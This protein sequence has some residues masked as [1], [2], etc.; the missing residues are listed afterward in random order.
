[1]VSTQ[2]TGVVFIR[3]FD[4]GVIETLGAEIR[5]AE[6]DG[7][8]RRSYYMD[9]IGVGTD[10][11]IIFVT[12]EVI[13]EKYYLPS[14]VVRREEP[15]F[16]AN[17]W[18]SI[19]M[20]YEMGVGSD[21]VVNGVTGKPYKES[22]VPAYPFDIT[23]TLEGLTRLRSQSVALLNVILRKYRPYG[24][25]A[26]KDSLDE[27][28]TYEAF[29]EGISSLD[30]LVDAGERMSGFAVSV[31]VIGELDLA[32]PETIKTAEDVQVNLSVIGED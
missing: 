17:R 28:R 9:I 20:A 16:A 3:D 1:M 22:K 21:V 25:V 12:P 2:R 30:E 27:V 18:H 19:S 32:D 15:S 24:K 14:I 11:P 13:M 8:S 5:T 23:Y 29:M 26:V 31:R 4:T 10:V 7:V 6:L